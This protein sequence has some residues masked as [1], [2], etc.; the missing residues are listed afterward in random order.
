MSKP[1]ER[2][3]TPTLAEVVRRAVEIC[4]PAD[5]N[6]DLGELLDAFQDD[7]EPV[8]AIAD[9]ETRI[10]EAVGRR[11]DPEPVDPSVTMAAA[12]A[13]YLAF[14]RDELG[15][16]PEEILRLA[17]RAEWKGKPPPEVRAWLEERGVDL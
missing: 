10:W 8:T 16:K 4:D 13:V 7:D 1:A 11:I 5:E 9:V 6:A 17:A 12:T 3:E 14:R 15:D 2:S